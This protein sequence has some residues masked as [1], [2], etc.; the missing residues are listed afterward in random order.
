MTNDLPSHQF[1]RHRPPPCPPHLHPLHHDNRRKGN[2]QDKEPVSRTKRHRP[3]HPHDRPPLGDKELRS[4]PER[5]RSP[6]PG[7]PEHAGPE[8]RPLPGTAVREGGE[9]LGDDDH[10]ERHGPGLCGKVRTSGKVPGKNPERD[11]SDHEAGED[12][13]F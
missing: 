2:Q 1:I 8:K 4:Q 10:R 3:E 12:E 7:I 9:Q 13:L 6:E 11:E 5:D